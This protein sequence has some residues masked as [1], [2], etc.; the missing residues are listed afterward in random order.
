MN[1]KTNTRKI[2][3]DVLRYKP[4]ETPVKMYTGK[5]DYREKVLKILKDSERP[6]N[7]NEI[8]RLAGI[9][10]WITAKSVMLDLMMSGEVE[11]FKSG[12]VLLYRVIKS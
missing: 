10:S 8:R 3:H 5:I 4:P 12:N 11:A 9:R 7:T 2:G 6:L 1:M